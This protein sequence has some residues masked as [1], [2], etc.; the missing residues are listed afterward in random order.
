MQEKPYWRSEDD[1]DSTDS[2]GYGS[3]GARAERP[4]P[5]PAPE[6][7]PEMRT[8]TVAPPLEG[9]IS[10]RQTE[11]S[12]DRAKAA[13]KSERSEDDD[14][15]DDEE[16]PTDRRAIGR[17][18]VPKK[19]GQHD[20][21][22]GDKAD[23]PRGKEAEDDVLAPYM[24]MSA[25]PAA[26]RPASEADSEADSDSDDDG[27][28]PPHTAQHF[29]P[30]HALPHNQAPENTP[31]EQQPVRATVHHTSEGVEDIAYF[32][33]SVPSYASPQNANIFSNRIMEQQ[34]SYAAPV[35]AENVENTNA[36]A[37]AAEQPPMPPVEPAVEAG[38]FPPPPPPERPA[39]QY[40]YNPA[41]YPGGPGEYTPPAPAPARTE[42]ASAPV[43]NHHHGEPLAVVAGIGVIAEH[44]GRKNAD[45]RQQEQ[46]DQFAAESAQRHKE[47]TAHNM[48]VEE[49]QRQ[50]NN[51][52][53]RQTAEMQRLQQAQQ[54][55]Y[56]QAPAAP[57]N[58]E[59]AAAGNQQATRYEAAP[60]QRPQGAE[61]QQTPQRPEQMSPAP[62][63]AEQQ[64]QQPDQYA[65]ELQP[66]QQGHVEHS[67]WHNIVVDKHGHEVSGAMQYGQEFYR[68]REHE[69][70]QGG[71]G[72]YATP[73]ADDTQDDQQAQSAL[74]PPYQQGQGALPSGMTNPI[75]PPGQP[76]HVDPQHQLPAASRKQVASNMAN[77]WFWLMLLLIVA[78]FFTAA[79]I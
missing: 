30:Q 27:I 44:I 65:P 43:D 7:P 51:E 60:G 33:E 38:M 72:A 63:G 57:Y 5:P 78:A 35:N 40:G 17:A 28:A 29:Q 55:R 14:D 13:N 23:E 32:R 67:A 2:R 69:M 45:H 52:Q 74:Q 46:L 10:W 21:A 66:N 54:E 79:L 16:E 20:E 15:D 41:M 37:D 24:E 64:L 53:Y 68:Q 25:A 1:K 36:V 71:A 50:Y 49:Q 59:H 34:P 18:A 42:H 12:L 3:Y 4:T 62:A 19:E 77:P 11:E 6:A 31:V 48:R 73:G 22:E 47:T 70:L 39:F 75:L 61:Q 58:L 26:E 76:T 8:P 9:I 56:N